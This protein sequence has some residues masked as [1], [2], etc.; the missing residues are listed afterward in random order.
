MANKKKKKKSRA[1][2]EE[3]DVRS[4]RPNSAQPCVRASPSH[5]YHGEVE[6]TTTIKP[7]GTGTGVIN[8]RPNSAREISLNVLKDMKKLQSTLRKDDL[9]WK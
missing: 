9:C 8:I 4:P 7:R 5:R 2:E 6:V 3:N 1:Q